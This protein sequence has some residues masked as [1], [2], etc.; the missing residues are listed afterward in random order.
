MPVSCAVPNRAGGAP[1][2]SGGL[3]IA[4]ETDSLAGRSLGRSEIEADF[5]CSYE[6]NPDYQAAVE[7]G[8]L[9]IS[10]HG[11]GGEARIVEL[12]DHRF[13][14]ATL[15][16]PQHNSTPERP[17]PLIAA[18]LQAAVAFHEARSVAQ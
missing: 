4:V 8:G 17:H 12:P 15:F 18:Y 10:G 11:E 6:L 2:L 5:F 16:L 14:L 13:F 1:S 7:A 3:R 9:R